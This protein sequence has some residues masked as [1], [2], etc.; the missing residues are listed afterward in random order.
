MTLSHL[1][2]QALGRT[3]LPSPVSSQNDAAEPREPRTKKRPPFRNPQ[4]AIQK[5]VLWS[6]NYPFLAKFTLAGPQIISGPANL[7]S[8]NYPGQFPHPK[9]S[10]LEKIVRNC[11]RDFVR[12]K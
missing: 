5:A 11:V 12:L 7:W 9:N 8:R 3:D 10:K 2:R 1:S 4:S 6:R